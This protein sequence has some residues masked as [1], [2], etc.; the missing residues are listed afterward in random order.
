MSRRRSG[1]RAHYRKNRGGVRPVADP[2]APGARPEPPVK[3]GR[4]PGPILQVLIVVM[5]AGISVAPIPLSV[6]LIQLAAGAYGT[7][8]TLTVESCVRVGRGRYD[9]EGT[10]TPD[11]GGPALTVSAPGDLEAGDRVTAQLAPEGDRAVVAGTRGVLT[12]LTLPFLSIGMFGFLPYVVLYWLPRSTRRQ[13]RKAV[14]AG[15]VLTAVSVVGVTI[16]L[17]ATYSV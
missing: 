4:S 1:G 9:C 5:W 10:F 16:G 14:I 15:C 13:L 17:I 11:G 12:T 2:P 6:P 3:T 7:P 8:G